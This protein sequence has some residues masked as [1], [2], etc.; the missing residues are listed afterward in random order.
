M[1][2]KASTRLDDVRLFVIAALKW[3]RADEYDEWRAFLDARQHF[4]A[5]RFLG[6]FLGDGCPDHVLAIAVF[7]ASGHVFFE[8]NL[9]LK[10]N[11]FQKKSIFK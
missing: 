6:W 2:P 3:V 9:P 7:F 10:T 8:N 4:K 1:A 11:S 5:T